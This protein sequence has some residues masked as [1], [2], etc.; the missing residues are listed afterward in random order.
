MLANVFGC[1]IEHKIIHKHKQSKAK[2]QTS[3]KPARMS[4]DIRPCTVRSTW[5]AWRCTLS[6]TK[7]E[8]VY[9]QLTISQPMLR[10]ML[11]VSLFWFAL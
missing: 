6:D 3:A 9:V 11:D 7:F 2:K 4:P 8:R 5:L 1:S 10:Q